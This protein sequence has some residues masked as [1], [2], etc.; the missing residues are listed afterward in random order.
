[1]AQKNDML[2]PKKKFFPSLIFLL[3]FLFISS[4]CLNAQTVDDVVILVADKKYINTDYKGAVALY[5]RFLKH[6]PDDFYAIRQC[7]RCFTYLNDPDQAIEYWTKVYENAKA[8]DADRLEY[9]RCLMANYRIEEG[10]QVLYSLRNSKD[11]LAASWAKTYSNSEFFFYEDSALCR[12]YAMNGFMSTQP[13][14]APY[15]YNSELL[16][17]TVPKKTFLQ[18]MFGSSK[19]HH[20]AIYSTIR[21]DSITWKKG[22]PFN[23]QIQN[24]YVNSAV[25]MS[26]NDSVIYYTSTYTSSEMKKGGSKDGVLRTGIF[27]TEINSNGLAHPE[28]KP[29]PVASVTCNV[30]HPAINK[31]GDKIYFASDMSGSLGGYD[32]WVCEK[33]NGVWGKAENLGPNVNSIGNE[34]Y[35]FLCD[36]GVLYFSSDGRPGM[37]SQDIFIADPAMEQGK[38]LEAENAGAGI[39]SQFNDFGI[40]L[41]PDGKRG[42][43][44]SNR[45]KGGD[46]DDIYFFSNNKPR[47]FQAKFIIR[48]SA[49][50]KSVGADI[51]ISSPLGTYGQRVDSGTVCRARIKPGQDIAVTIG[52]E[53]YVTRILNK[54]VENTDTLFVINMVPRF[55]RCIEGKIIDKESGT[56]IAGM[57]VA[58]YDEDGTNYLDIETDA[59]GAYKAC[60]LP[61]DKD[62]YIGAAKK[63]DYFSNTERFKITKGNDIVKDI[64]TQK[65]VIG[66]AIKVE[67][68]YFDPSK[69]DVREDAKAELDKL[70]SLMKNNPDIIIELS[71]HSDCKGPAAPNLTLS[72]KR[73]K[74]SAAYIVSKGINK[75]RIKGK[76][77]GETKLLNDCGCEGKVESKCSDE[78]HAINRRTEFK[79]TGFVTEKKK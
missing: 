30:A 64:F 17:V 70:V 8:N 47:P 1:M 72:D 73:A 20:S 35:P 34:M 67:N 74:A 43:F 14:N 68:I 11:P 3:T 9:A 12:V 28:K 59:S 53:T 27:Y 75:D 41:M 60:K 69:F 13:E 76:G 31:A 6:H 15:L 42:Y 40:F 79:V 54:K 62:L 44:S 18:K 57:K 36:D 78:Q 16:Y 56:P 25:C 55:Q 2:H 63:P 21:V 24:K 61:L 52:A 23:P 49:E 39:N 26:G 45:D 51:S 22:K 77:Y 7:G 33:K 29:L 65:I 32:I 48:D 5:K 37:G 10:K 4:P 58:I 50:N 19:N 38:F 71:S 66:K 46:D